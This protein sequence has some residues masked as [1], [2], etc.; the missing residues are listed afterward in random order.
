VVLAGLMLALSVVSVSFGTNG[1]H[2]A[3]QLVTVLTH[4][5]PSRPAA[6]KVGEARA[7][8]ATRRLERRASRP[9][10]RLVLAAGE[11]AALC[12][13]PRAPSFDGRHLYMQ[14]CTLRC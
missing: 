6:A 2:E 11:R 9:A 13:T 5:L 1:R 8:A 10:R 12:H 7:A 4:A 3:R 14:N